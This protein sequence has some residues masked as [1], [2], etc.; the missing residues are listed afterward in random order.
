MSEF[1]EV[2]TAELEGAALDSAVARAIG[3]YRGNYQFSE[4]GPMDKAWIFPGEIP[5]KA[6]TGKFSPS[7]DWSQGG[8]LIE[9][10]MIG[11]GVYSDAYFAV[12]GLNDRSGAENGPTHLIAACRAIVAAVLGETVQVPKGLCQ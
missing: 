3:A 2:K 11:F 9:K 10:Y 4:S 1:V 12:I 8:P 5:C 7:T 6:T